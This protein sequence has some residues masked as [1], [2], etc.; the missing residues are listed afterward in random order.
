MGRLAMA[1]VKENV[2]N[3]DTWLRGLFIL[4]FAVFFYFLCGIIWLLVLVQFIFKI[5]TGSLNAQLEQFS[6]SL[7]QYALQI[8]NYVTFRSEER[9]FPFSPW[10]SGKSG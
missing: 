4:I 2:K 6:G 7:V 9:P 10:P 3:V 5:T 8:L 1:D